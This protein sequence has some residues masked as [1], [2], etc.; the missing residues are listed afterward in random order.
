MPV[1]KTIV[2]LEKKM[3]F[4]NLAKTRGLSESELLRVIVKSSTEQK[5]ETD[6]ISVEPD[7]TKVD[8]E[9][10]TVRLP[11]FLME[12]AR[13]KA[14]IKYMALSRWISSLVQSNLTGKPVMTKKELA[15][16]RESNRELAAIGRNVN[17]IA[18]TL[19]ESFYKVESVRLEKL[20]ELRKEIIE[21]RKAIQA[22][23]RA[24]ENVW[25]VEEWL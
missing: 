17:Q 4:Q 20:E 8:L 21:N 19:N 22:L 6:I 11:R 10:V 23:I 7:V 14:E 1:L 25:E 2:G 12:A 15:V 9:R 3:R 5:D 18:R 16:L 13:N 24:S